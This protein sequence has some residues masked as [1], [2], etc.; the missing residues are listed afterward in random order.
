MKQIRKKIVYPLLA[1]AWAGM[2]CNDA[3][4]A[5]YQVDES[6]ASNQT[7]ME[8]IDL[9][10]DL[11]KFASMIRTVAYDTVLVSDQSFTVWAPADAQLQEVDMN[12]NEEILN[13]VKNHIARFTHSAS[14]S[15][16]ENVYMVNGKTLPFS[17]DGGSYTLGGQPL[18]ASGSN[19]AARN[20]LL[21]TLN[22]RVPFLRNI[23]EYMQYPE[24]DS[25]RT[26]LYSFDEK[27][28]RL[29]QSISIDIR[30]GLI[31]YDSVFS[32]SNALWNTRLNGIG[33][34]NDEDST[35]TMLLPTN[36]AWIEAYERVKP[37]YLSNH[38]QMADSFQR[39]NTQY[40]LVQDLV[41]RGAHDDISDLGQSDALVSTRQSIF[42][43]PA[44]LFAG[45]V[46]QQVSNGWVYPI[47]QLHHNYWESWNKLILIE[48]ELPRG[49]EVNAR[50]SLFSR[51]YVQDR[52][53]VSNAGFLE[54]YSNVAA[55]TNRVD[56]TFEIPEILSASYDIYCV[57]LPNTIPYPQRT[58]KKTKLRFEVAQLNRQ[59]GQ[60]STIRSGGGLGGAIT[61]VFPV[62]GLTNPNEIT[63]MLVQRGFK[64]PFASVGELQNLFRIKATTF[65]TA[66]LSTDEYEN[67][68]YID[69]ILLLPTN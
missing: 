33:Y 53:D 9:Q 18:I 4:D 28:F 44:R 5:H 34:L 65:L 21:H 68:M 13:I 11:S 52:T 46:P 23:W 3:L 10:P 37:Y 42:Y 47:N 7:L 6:V 40:A 66:N 58:P 57:L 16:N 45:A 2:S 22:G 30:D 31:V 67:G 15:E 29:S 25:I 14:G 55:L 27:N 35:Y 12:N 49:R 8:L 61:P 69:C 62:D 41:F 50:T 54:V 24:F 36:E 26:Y 51:Y 17:K 32:Y 39:A 19:L 1:L 59:T 63:Y 64:F 48:A 43:D 56:V 38:P 60:W 20:G